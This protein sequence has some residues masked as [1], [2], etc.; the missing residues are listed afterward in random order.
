MGKRAEQAKKRKRQQ[1]SV[2]TH[3]DVQKIKTSIHLHSPSPSAAIISHPEIETTVLTL[4]ALAEYPDELARKEVKDV[5]RAIYALQRVM[6]DGQTLGELLRVICI[7]NGSGTSLTSRI[8]TA[9]QDYRFTDAL[10]L[11]FEMYTRKLPP[12]L[13]SLQRWVRECDATVSADGTIRDV[14][15]MK[16]LDLIL[17]IAN[18]TTCKDAVSGKHLVRRRPIWQARGEVEGEIPIWER[19]QA[20]KL[21]GRLIILIALIRRCSSEQA[22]FQLYSGPPYSRTSP[23]T[24]K[25]I[26]FNR[27][28]ILASR[29]QAHSAISAST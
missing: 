10:I 24:T 26:R 22:I 29:H 4:E 11:L 3:L 14:D 19:M 17:R 28:W 7:T 15:A 6:A 27:V 12:K 25:S 20:R 1:T 9:L 8:S 5:K 16:C 21:F 23:Q 18:P 2:F 13:G